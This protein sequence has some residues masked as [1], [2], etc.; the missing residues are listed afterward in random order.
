M[1]ER[2]VKSAWSKPA[3]RQVEP[4]DELLDLCRLTPEEKAKFLAKRRKRSK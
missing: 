1:S 2:Q 3:L 4:T